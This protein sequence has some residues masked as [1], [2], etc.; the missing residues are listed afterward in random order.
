MPDGPASIVT[1]YLRRVSAPL[2]ARTDC[3]LLARY[4][5][6]R[7]DE[8]FAQLVRRHGR[9][10]LGV[11]RRAL[12]STPDADDAFQATFLALARH[13]DRVSDCVPGWLYRVA[14]R[15]SRRALRRYAP[16]GDRLEPADPSD[17]L[18]AVEWRDV[19]R[20]L[21]D[22][23]N[24]LP[25]RLR[26][27]LVLCYLESLTR[28]EAAKR[29]GWSLRTLHRR[30]D[31]GRTRLRTR[32]TRRGLAPTL[33]ATA[34]LS[35]TELRADVPP[36]LALQTTALTR[37]DA[38]VPSSVDSLVPNMNAW[39]GMAMKVAISAL[40]LAGGVAVTLSVRQPT[41]ADPA[42]PELPT[43]PALVLAPVKKDKPAP[44]PLA[45][46]V[47]EA[48]E[49]GIKYL[50]VQQMNQG[51]DVW[52][53]ENDTLT[54]LQE[55]GTSALAVLALLENGLKADDQAVARGLRY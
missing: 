28:D 13:A 38:T 20:L 6:T 26:T 43:G 32:L 37:A 46:K 12:G 52:N 11:C 47:K 50:K 48:Q 55:G 35:T 27:P 49:K 14:V 19:R 22:E 3:E 4:A 24:Q 29:L 17:A 5:A 53:W 39:G 54:V 44:D 36:P 33:L 42:R 25:E 18:A 10:V 45:A 16:A 8:A 41:G 9:M 51:G 2:E 21:D 1:D 23:L 30:L 7:D 31:E 34:V 40:V 15:T